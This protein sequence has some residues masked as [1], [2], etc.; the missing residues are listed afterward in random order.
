MPTLYNADLKPLEPGVYTHSYNHAAKLFVGDNFR[1]APKQTS[2]YYVVIEIDPSQTQLGGGLVAE[3]LSFVDRFSNLQNGLLVKKIELP[4]Y[5]IGTKTMNAYNRKSI[6]QTNITYEPVSVTFHDDAADLIT[7]FWNDYYTYYFRDSDYNTE[8]YRTSH[9]YQARNKVGWGYSPHNGGVATTNNGQITS[10]IKTIRIFSLHNKRFTEYRLINPVIAS[11][12]HGQHDAYSDNGTMENNMTVEY[13][14]VKYFTGYVNPVDVL[15]FSLL[16]YDTTSSPISKSVTNIYT[17]TGILGAVENVTRDLARP[18]GAGG[19]GGPL[20]NVLSA[21]RLYNNLKNVNINTVLGTTLAQVGGQILNNAINSGLQPFVFP[22]PGQGGT[23]TSNNNTFGVNGSAFG[24]P[25]G[26]VSIS[27]I[28]AGAITGAAI[29]AQNQFLNRVTG[30]IN[31]GLSGLVN[32]SATSYASRVTDVQGNNGT[33]T[34]NPQTQQPVTQ[35]AVAMVLNDEGMPVA[36]IQVTGTQSGRYN[37]NNLTENLSWATT[38]TDQEGREVIVNQYKDGTQVTYDALSGNQL[39]LIPGNLNSSNNINTNPVNASALAAQGFNTAATGTQFYTNPTTG[40]VYTVGGTTTARL[41]NTISGGFAGA[42][43]FY[44][45]S[46][47]NQALTNVFGT[48][49]IGRTVSGAISGTVGA[50]VGRAVNNGLQP[51]INQ[52]T[53]AVVQGF[54]SIGQNIKNV[55]GTWTGL[56]GFDA[57]KPLDN[58]VTKQIFDDGSQLFTYKDGT[59]R[60]IDSAGTES[61]TPGS[62][63]WGFSSFWNKVS[64]TNSDSQA[65]SPAYG[66]IWTDGYGNPVQTG[67]GDYVYSGGDTQLQPTN[68]SDEDWAAQGVADQAALN[69]WAGNNTEPYNTTDNTGFWGYDWYE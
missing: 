51:I 10:F 55:I 31:R 15:G 52:A 14:T 12:R 68:I 26:A 4:K 32:P 61:I 66:T 67:Y 2:L 29:N 40:L 62:S 39:Q 7:N 46:T 9:R 59:V 27:G 13:E 22:Q 33:I 45:A 1:L 18:D 17:D 53:G 47:V 36:S 63:N 30:E 24:F 23:Q 8:A 64:G 20:S 57:S 16:N 34:V 19:A 5:N 49:V 41:T 60:S 11:W 48:S 28:A 35:S 42:A 58:I 65:A 6:I 37:P 44:T 25:G 56:G 69:Y 50:V 3:A 38:T 43:G 21:Y 54:D